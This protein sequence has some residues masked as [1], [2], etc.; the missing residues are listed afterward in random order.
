MKRV[1]S[2]C[3]LRPNRPSR[4]PNTSMSLLAPFGRVGLARGREPSVDL[5]LEQLR[6]FEQAYDFRPHDLVEK[7]LAHRPI[8]TNKLAKVP[9]GIGAEATVIVDLAGA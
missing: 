8:V 2:G 6:I 1:L 4:F 7:V 3:S 5:T 9:I